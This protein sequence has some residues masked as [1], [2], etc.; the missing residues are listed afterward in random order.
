MQMAPTFQE[1]LFSGNPQIQQRALGWLAQVGNSLL[2]PNS[3]A[4]V[5]GVNIADGQI[6]LT[7]TNK[8]DGSKSSLTEDTS[9]DPDAKVLSLT[10]DQAIDLLNTH[11]VGTVN[12]Q[13]NPQYDG[14]RRS[15]AEQT[16]EVIADTQIQLSRADPQ[17]GRSFAGMLVDTTPE[18]K[19]EI[20]NQ[21]LEAQG[22]P[23]LQGPE[24][25][26]LGEAIAPEPFVSDADT[27]RAR[28]YEMSQDE[29][30]IQTE[31]SIISDYLTTGNTSLTAQPGRATGAQSKEPFLKGTNLAKSF[32]TLH[33][34]ANKNSVT[35]SE[36][37]EEA[38]EFVGW[39]AKNEVELSKRI[40]SN[41][42]V[43]DEIEEIGATEFARKYQS[44]DLSTPEGSTVLDIDSAVNQATGGTA[45]GARDAAANGTLPK[46]DQT[47]LA[48]IR[49]MVGMAGVDPSSDE[50]IKQQVARLL[51]DPQKRALIATAVAYADTPEN[52]RK[53]LDEYINLFSTGDMNESLTDQ[54]DQKQ[55]GQTIKDNR[56]KT[57]VS[58]AKHY[59]TVAK[60]ARDEARNA[61][62]EKLGGYELV[63][64][65]YK[66]M[67]DE[68][69]NFQ[70]TDNTTVELN[71]LGMAANAGGEVGDIAKEYF[72]PSVI[73]YLKVKNLNGGF[74]ES[75]GDFFNAWR[76]DPQVQGGRG[77][78]KNDVR[79]LLKDGGLKALVIKD[80][81]GADVTLEGVE[82]M[83]VLDPETV[84]LLI[85]Q[86][87][88]NEEN[89][90]IA[91]AKKNKKN[92]TK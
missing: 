75:W 24:Q 7:T 26:Q 79:V 32:R 72:V 65:F 85:A 86:A 92:A 39:Y 54:I 11:M 18:E 41:P 74:S 56:D 27:Q 66:S 70:I 83:R 80:S 53:I 12:R 36:V 8:K 91:Q 6:R 69:G 4:I 73:D 87:G 88:K 13:A 68:G 25:P 34:N 89:A 46:P 15:I 47:Q 3:D 76:T 71:A 2:T 81:S 52:G 33:R 14:T 28:D 5:T 30:R 64:D 90:R 16:L 50:P 1:D 61:S 22:L 59:E 29:E 38:T 37:F 21:A 77:N 42:A 43:M 10:I 58:L 31:T 51:Q 63:T 23:P 82:I 48:N 40:Q 55:A 45:D 78:S 35:T 44:L 57:L 19:T 9:N 49:S 17:A 67:R 62:K 84:R 20:A 60:N